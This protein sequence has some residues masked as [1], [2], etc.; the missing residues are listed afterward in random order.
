MKSMKTLGCAKRVTVETPLGERRGAW[1][2][3]P[4]GFGRIV[5]PR[6][7]IK[8]ELDHGTHLNLRSGALRAPLTSIAA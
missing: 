7:P 1:D 4:F 8:V 2:C 5:T 6:L 3:R